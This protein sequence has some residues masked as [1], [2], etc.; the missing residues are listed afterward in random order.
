MNILNMKA[1]ATATVVHCDPDAFPSG[2]PAGFLELSDGIYE[3]TEDES[4]DPTWLCSSVQVKSLSRNASGTGWGRIVIVVNPEGV[5]QDVA[6]LDSEIERSRSSVLGRLTDCGL[7]LRS[8][9][10]ARDAFMRLLKEWAPVSVLTSIDRL[11]WSDAGCAAF[12]LGD[13]RV[14]GN[15]KFHFTGRK[16]AGADGIYAPAGTIE[17]WRDNVAAL[18]IGNPLMTLSVSLAFEGP[19]LEM[20]NE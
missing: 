5:N 10:K 7:K 3:E 1:A 19:L 16:L 6:L 20:L 18:C 8:G 15:G 14:I 17:G 12:V 2:I 4:A 11:G 9:T 13:G